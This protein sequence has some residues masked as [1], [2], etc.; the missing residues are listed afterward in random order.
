MHLPDVSRR[1]TKEKG[2]DIVVCT[3]NRV[4]Q[5][6]AQEMR[7]LILLLI[8]CGDFN[9]PRTEEAA[10]HTIARYHFAS[11]RSRP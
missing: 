5:E 1:E 6:G 8:S 3:A 2:R 10:E 4:E 11:Y 9:P 7:E